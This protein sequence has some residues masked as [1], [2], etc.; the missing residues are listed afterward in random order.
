MFMSW[1]QSIKLH[2]R[3]TNRENIHISHFQMF[4]YSFSLF[5]ITEENIFFVWFHFE[6]IKT[7]AF[8]ILPDFWIRENRKEN[9]WENLK[10]SKLR[11]LFCCLYKWAQ[12]MLNLSTNYKFIEGNDDVLFSEFNEFIYFSFSDINECETPEVTKSCP[13]GCENTI[14]SYRCVQ[15]ESDVE[16][17]PTN[18]ENEFQ[19][20]E[21]NAPVK[22]CG[23][24][25][26]LDD[27]NNCIDVC[28]LKQYWFSCIQLKIYFDLRRS[29]SAG[30]ATL[31]VSIVKIPLVDSN[32]YA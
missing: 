22:A 18:V 9:P 3:Y 5:V 29:M 8:A 30:K 28:H 16:I 12:S 25:L 1:C 2:R 7:Y 32:V 26:R 23:D 15:S 19:P 24:G 20:T 31:I 6:N 11:Q 17:I 13:N 27:L 10:N 21:P 4:I 14:G